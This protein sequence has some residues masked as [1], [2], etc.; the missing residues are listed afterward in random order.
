[1]YSAPIYIYIYIYIYVNAHDDNN[2]ASLED[3]NSDDTLLVVC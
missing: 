1:M 3:N 2:D